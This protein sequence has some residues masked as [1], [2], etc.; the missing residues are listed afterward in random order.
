MAQEGEVLVVDQANWISDQD[1]R[2]RGQ[3]AF[4]HSSDSSS[5]T[6]AAFRRRE[7]TKVDGGRAAPAS[8]KC[9]G[10]ENADGPEKLRRG[11]CIGG[12]PGNFTSCELL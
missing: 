2:W 1:S 8:E 11:G 9:G 6:H 4:C 7:V 5:S 12:I 10:E 3:Q